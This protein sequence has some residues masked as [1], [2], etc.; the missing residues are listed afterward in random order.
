M[1][2]MQISSALTWI[3]VGLS[4]N[5]TLLFRLVNNVFD[6]VGAIHEEGCGGGG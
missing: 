1:E 3:E 4:A 5:V 2:D 6:H